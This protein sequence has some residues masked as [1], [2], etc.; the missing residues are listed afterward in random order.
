MR[1]SF[2]M[3]WHEDQRECFFDR[4]C[5]AGS[6]SP[7][8]IPREQT[9]VISGESPKSGEH[10]YRP[11][12]PK[13][14]SSLSVMR[15]SLARRAS[16]SNPFSPARSYIVNLAV[17]PSHLQLERWPLVNSMRTPAPNSWSQLWLTTRDRSYGPQRSPHSWIAATVIAIAMAQAKQA[18]DESRYK[19]AEG[20]FL[21]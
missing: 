6:I 14:S 3:R 18:G 12:F 17:A 7:V 20:L 4:L 19:N 10:M 8:V 11:G 21:G 9:W 5:M 1:L 16:R 13:R 15:L 2:R